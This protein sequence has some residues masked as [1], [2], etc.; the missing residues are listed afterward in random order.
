MRL[1]SLPEAI[2][3]LSSG[4]VIVYPTETL[5]AVGGLALAEKAVRGV[6]QVKQ[7]EFSEPLPIIIGHEDQLTLL[8]RQ[9]PAELLTLLHILWPGPLTVIFSAQPGLP[10]V[11]TAGS[12][13]VAVRLT[14][15]PIARELCLH[16]GPL[17]ASSANISGAAPAARVELISAQL[18]DACAGVLDL[19][20][21]PKGGPPSTLIELV[22]PSTLRLA[23]C[24]AISADEL[25]HMGWDVLEPG[26]GHCA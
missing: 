1:F 15:H 9:V 11:L 6:Y 13:K 12:G 16:C 10:A 14:S 5:F 22:D 23:R 3:A 18:L 7:R 24:G 4:E 8:A 25:R 21:L 17:T 26:Q 20:P 19:P 2:A